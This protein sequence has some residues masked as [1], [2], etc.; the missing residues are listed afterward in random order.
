MTKKSN[1]KVTRVLVFFS[2]VNRQL[3]TFASGM[4]PSQQKI[5]IKEKIDDHAPS[6]HLSE[7]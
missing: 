1:D 6:S 4:L 5:N 7:K 3:S 2:E